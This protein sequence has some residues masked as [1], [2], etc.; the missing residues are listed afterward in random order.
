MAEMS[1]DSKSTEKTWNTELYDGKNAFVWKHGR[2]V[3][4]LLSPQPGERILDLGCGTGHLT[5]Q[6]ATAGAEVVGL[7]KS[8][9]MIEGARKLYPSLRFEIADAMEFGFEQP[10]DAVFSNAAIHW[11]K[12][13]RAVARSI[14]GALKEGG[15]FVAEFGGKGNI[16]AI[17]TALTDAVEAA[18]ETINAEPFARYYPA[19]G[20]YATLL[21]AQGFRVT[22]ATHF[23][24]PTKLDEG[25]KGLRN[26]LLTFAD[27]VIES[28][29]EGK[30]E[31]VIAQVEDALRPALFRDGT[32]FADYRRIR[33]VAVRES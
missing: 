32:W 13:Q 6:I 1:E 25:D 33:I 31:P 30:R 2:G 26:W 28:L 16:R 9:S 3:V 4:E 21:E 20:E 5:N 7:D 29:P 18:D 23:D 14:W 12:D 10:F 24:R 11:M 15:R 19:I 22:F 17:R 8:P 27:N